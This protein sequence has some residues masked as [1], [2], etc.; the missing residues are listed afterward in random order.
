MEHL[1]S[2]WHLVSQGRKDRKQGSGGKGRGLGFSFGWCPKLFLD[3]N[4]FQFFCLPGTLSYHMR[5]LLPSSPSVSSILPV[6]EVLLKDR[7]SQCWLGVGS[8]SWLDGDQLFLCLEQVTCSLCIVSSLC[9]IGIGLLLTVQDRFEDLWTNKYKEL[10]NSTW[11]IVKNQEKLAILMDFSYF[12]YLLVPVLP[13]CS[14][15]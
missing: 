15:G 5:S 7:E 4:W 14:L 9:K 3:Q 1:T 10:R 6:R 11:Q 2:K 13:V 8:D 12:Y